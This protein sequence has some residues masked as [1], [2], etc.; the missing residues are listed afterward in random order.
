MTKGLISNFLEAPL[1]IIGDFVLELVLIFMKLQER[2]IDTLSEYMGPVFQISI[3]DYITYF[4]VLC[5]FVQ[6]VMYCSIMQQ[7]SPAVLAPWFG[8]I[9]DWIL[10]KSQ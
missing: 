2:T 4:K 6:R 5:I 7:K 8:E 1:Q 3:L 9:I 10:Q